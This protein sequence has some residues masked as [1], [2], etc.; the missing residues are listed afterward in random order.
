MTEAQRGW[1][2]VSIA[3]ALR[4]LTQP[5]APYEMETIEIR[6]RP[7]RVYKK[8][9]RDLRALFEASRAWDDRVFIVY[10]DERLSYRAH[11]R[12]ASALAWRLVDD[13]A[14]GKGD[15]VAIAMRNFPE[16][17]IAFW[18]ATSIG[19]VAVPLNAWGTG[20]DLS[21]GLRNSGARVTMVDAE[22]LQRL[23]SQPAD[24]ISAA[25]IAV[26]TPREAL[27]KATALDDLIG[28]ATGYDSLPDRAPPDRDIHPDDDATILYTSG[29]T[30]RPKGAL[31]THRNIMCNLVNI[32]FAAA[33]AAIR[34]G[35]PLPAPAATQKAVLLPV[36]LFHVTGCH[37]VMIP[38]LAGGS[39]IV[40]MYK[41]NAEQALELIARERIAGISSVP[42]MIWQLIES[43]EFERHDLSSLEGLSYGGAAAAPELARKITALFPGKFPSQGY[44]A[45]ETSSV[46]TSNTAEDYLARPAS[47]GPAVPGCDLRVIDVDGK[48]LPVGAIG[49]LEIFGGNVVKGYWDNPEATAKAFRDGWYRTG[50]IVRMDDEGFVYLLDRAKDMLIRGGENI[51]CVEIEDALLSHPDII[52]AAV[53]GI[54]DRVLGELVG[55]VVQTKAGAALSEEDV[56][57]YLK[58]RLAAFKLPAHVDVR[59]GELPRTASGKIVKTRLREEVVGT[60]KASSG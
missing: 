46:S 58:P 26:R 57:A 48:P 37:S 38:A 6:G 55:A 1:P 34:R 27:G 7:T 25:L 19:A 21:F 31:G 10:E 23:A 13:F 5:D 2:A 17:S 43:P 52:D 59:V 14:V 50:D 29:T 56:V 45:T 30:G 33:R 54:P 51:Y 28:P 3:E 12:A 32:T 36:P 41:W 42:S 16:W 20:D 60:F 24:E 8:A 47:V 4:I 40:L 35:D 44:G 53:V 11:F 49:E 18:A 22:R 39:K 15:R 9:P